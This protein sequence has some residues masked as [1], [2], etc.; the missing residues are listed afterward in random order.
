[1]DTTVMLQF[2]SKYNGL[3]LPGSFIPAPTPS[4]QAHMKTEATRL[5]ILGMK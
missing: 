4:S 5:I 1:M 3:W 2:Y